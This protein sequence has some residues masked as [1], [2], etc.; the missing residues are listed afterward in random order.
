LRNRLV[1]EYRASQSCA[2][3]HR[4]ANL[5]ADAPANPLMQ[6][7]V[8]MPVWSLKIRVS[9]VPADLPEALRSFAQAFRAAFPA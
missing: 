8:R 7:M 1:R 2:V 5:A 3:L 9:V 4:K 6:L